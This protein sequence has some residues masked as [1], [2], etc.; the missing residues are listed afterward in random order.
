[1]PETSK[2]SGADTAERGSAWSLPSHL[3][4]DR[5]AL[6]AS[7][8]VPERDLVWVS[9][10]ND[11]EGLLPYFIALDRERQCVVLAIRGTMSAADAL[12]GALGHACSS[13]VRTGYCLA[14]LAHGSPLWAVV[15]PCRCPF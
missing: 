13:S 11:A 8:G 15:L 4:L 10:D 6:L 2:A 5:F 7:L 14:L 3:A 12:T 9:H 1:M